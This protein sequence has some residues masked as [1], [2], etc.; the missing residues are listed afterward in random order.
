MNKKDYLVDYINSL[1]IPFVCL[2]YSDIEINNIVNFRNK[3]KSNSD[4]EIIKSG[5]IDYIKDIT[6]NLHDLYNF[7]FNDYK[8][9]NVYTFILL[10]Y[11]FNSM[12][13]RK[14]DV[15]LKL[16]KMRRFIRCKY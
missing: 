15:E 14:K 1:L 5:V 4:N 7:Y 13:F 10:N 12:T 6:W 3:I 8:I 16:L 9:T 2:L 11:D